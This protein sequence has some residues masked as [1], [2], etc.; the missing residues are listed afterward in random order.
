MPGMPG[1]PPKPPIPGRPLPS[2]FCIFSSSSTLGIPCIPSSEAPSPPAFSCSFCSSAMLGIPGIFGIAGP[3]LGPRPLAG[4]R[5]PFLPLRP[6]GFFLVA[7]RPWNWP[8]ICPI[9]FLASSKRLTNWLTSAT[10]TPEPL[11]IRLRREAFRMLGFARSS[12]VMPRMIA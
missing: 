2:C 11:A 1:K 3:R 7:E 6:L 12:G 10:V 4:L 5:L 9:I 8:V